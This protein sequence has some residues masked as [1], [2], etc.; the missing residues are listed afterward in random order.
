MHP[1]EPELELEIVLVEPEEEEIEMSFLPGPVVALQEAV[2]RNILNHCTKR[3]SP[4][5]L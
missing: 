2:S 3:Q 5:R 4:L 1:D